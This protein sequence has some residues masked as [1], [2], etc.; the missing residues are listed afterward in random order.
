MH[1]VNAVHI[2]CFVVAMAETMRIM[3]MV[4]MAG[5]VADPPNAITKSNV[6][7]WIISVI[8]IQDI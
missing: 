3:G 8:G 6:S 2:S 7:L 5:K 1:V 4:T